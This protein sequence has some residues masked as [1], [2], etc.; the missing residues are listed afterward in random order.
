MMF[1]KVLHS[2]M[3]Q[4]LWELWF[5]LQSG[6]RNAKAKEMENLVYSTIIELL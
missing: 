3:G 1:W 5:A 6:K 2:N 4:P